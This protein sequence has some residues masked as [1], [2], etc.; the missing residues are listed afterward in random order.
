MATLNRIVSQTL[1]FARTLSVPKESDLVDLTEAA[2]RIHQRTIQ[3]KKIHLVKDLPLGITAEIR[4]G[5]ILQVVSNLIVNALDALSGDGTL[6]VR[7][8]KRRDHVHI[9][10]ADNGH[11]S[12]AGTCESYIR[13]VLY[14]QGRVWN[15]AWSPSL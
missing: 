12:T 4:V 11:G 5:E 15:R 2:L 13:A 9:L 14:D 8:R 10:I 3:A 6:V 1:G 7:L